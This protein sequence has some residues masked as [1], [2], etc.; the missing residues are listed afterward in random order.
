MLGFRGHFST[1]SRRYS[2]TLGALRQVRADYRAAQQ[3][4]ALG[5]PDPDDDP[6]T[7]TLTLAHWTYAGHGHTLGE[8]WLAANIRRDIQ[9]NRETAREERAALLDLEGAAA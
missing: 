5:L 1:K 3:R 7:T 4:S 8:S 2:T 6:E 9:H